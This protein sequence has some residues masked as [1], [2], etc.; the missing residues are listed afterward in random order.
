MLILDQ[1][2]KGDPRLRW[3][4]LGVLAGIL[5]LLTGLWWVQIASYR[6]YQAHLETQTYRSVRIPAARGKILD[7]NGIALAENRPEYDVNL[8]FEDLRDQFREEYD[9]IRPV[10]V[11]TNSLPFWKRWLGFNLV[12]TQRVRLDK[13]QVEA[14]EWQARY[15]VASRAVRRIAAC[16]QTLLS[17]D[18]EK[19]KHHY[20]KRLALPYPVLTDLN[21]TQVARL[22]EQPDVPGSAD[23]DVQ[24]ERYYPYQTT[25]GHV[26]GY[27]QQDNSSRKGEEAYFSYRLPDYRGVVG[28]EYGFDVQLRGQAGAKSVLVNNLG[29]RQTASVW[30]PA[31]PGENVVLTIDLYI[32]QAAEKALHRFGPDVRGAVVVMNVNTGDILAMVSSPAVNPNDFIQGISRSEAAY[33]NDPTLRPQINRATQ[34]NYAPGSIFKPVVALACLKAGLDPNAE[35]DNPGYIYVG[36]RH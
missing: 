20:L 9:R 4:A 7:C 29:Y 24:P 31:E 25:A 19:F 35:I 33:L 32:Q 23:L 2:R 10:R 28:I 34:A 1:L 22:E 14:L 36:H 3:L 21:S 8:Y 17:L 30:S 11:V 15:N 18:P 12:T 26:L 6:N 13:S 16:T 27:L 5:I